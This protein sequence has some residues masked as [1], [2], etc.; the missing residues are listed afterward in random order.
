MGPNYLCV[1]RA[2]PLLYFVSKVFRLKS[3]E[4][5]NYGKLK[6]LL[7]KTL[8]VNR[9]APDLAFDWSEIPQSDL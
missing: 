5:P 6:F 7:T 3:T 9:I 1:G 8:L 2:K 4:V